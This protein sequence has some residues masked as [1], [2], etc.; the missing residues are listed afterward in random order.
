MSNEVEE[1]AAEQG[2]GSAL[3]VEESE[4]EEERDADC[5]EEDIEETSA[6]MHTQGAYALVDERRKNID[7]VTRVADKRAHIKEEV[8][9]V[10][11]RA[12][13]QE[14]RTIRTAVAFSKQQPKADTMENTTTKTPKAPE[15]G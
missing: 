2:H 5:D 3:E 15:V 1:Q 10:S 7:K 4:M 11:T 9:E 8:P 13:Y 14:K 6:V 12:S